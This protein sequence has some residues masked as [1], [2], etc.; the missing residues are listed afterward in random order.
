LI[1]REKA[2]HSVRALCR[3]LGVSPSGYYAW[4]DREPSLR[5]RADEA[6]SEQIVTIHERSRQTY[7]VLRIQAEL[8]VQGM[9]CGKRRIAQLMRAAGVVGCHR[10]K[11]LG[12]TVRDPSA[13]AAADLVSRR[14]LAEA[15]NRLWVADITYVPT[16][17]GFLYLAVV[18]DAFSRRVV[19]WCMA[20]HLR[21]ALVLSALEMALWNR[22][23]GPGLVHHSDQGCQYTSIT[24]GHRCTEAG[25]TLS[26]GSVGDCYDNALAEA[27]FATLECEL[28]NR[29]RFKTKLDARLAIF[30]Y[31]ETFYNRERRHSA[32]GYLAPAAYE[33]AATEAA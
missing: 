19:G 8:R 29:H 7:G 31:L 25:I 14:F 22:R 28:L 32:L 2:H 16:W 13:P 15:P 5:A 3:V 6:L 27:F 12:L 4:R 1:E 23:P 18:L 21:T 9:R 20:D 17:A 26:M 33:Q 10:R 11:R 30:D 24:F